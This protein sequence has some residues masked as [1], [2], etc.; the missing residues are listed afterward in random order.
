MREGTAGCGAFALA[1]FAL[2]CLSC[3]GVAPEELARLRKEA[4]DE[5]A[6]L[7]AAHDA[8][9][10]PPEAWSIEIRGA[11]AGSKTM[12]TAARIEA[13]ADREIRTI[14][15]SPDTGYKTEHKYKG[16]P[17][18][19]VLGDLPDAGPD[20][21]VTVIGV[22]G[23]WTTLKRVDIE[24][25]P[26]LLAIERDGHRIPRHLGGPVLLALPL[27]SYPDFAVRYGENGWC[28]YVGAI[29]VG[30]PR[31]RIRIGDTVREPSDLLAKG[32]VRRK[33]QVRFRRG[34]S[35]DES[36]LAGVRLADLF[37]NARGVRVWSFGREEGKEVVV[38]AE[39][40]KTCDPL[41]VIGESPTKDP[42]PPSLGG[43]ALL[44]PLPDC[45]AM[46]AHAAWP[47]FIDTLEAVP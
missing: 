43:P 17:L 28:Y 19:R 31:A 18:S 47:T 6:R 37:P 29:G 44:A 9:A 30:R 8:G 45:P 40:M 39:D 42:I 32:I 5:D 26:I 2:T 12:L 7:R 20:T 16:V 10:P 14:A 27:S 41:L 33:Q 22:D 24:Q 21:E 11:A 25:A 3:Q 34:W 38:T 15:P 23:F 4:K 1:I 46:W 35:G 36:A 13:M